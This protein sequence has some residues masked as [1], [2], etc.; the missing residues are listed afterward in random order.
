MN[1]VIGSF[2]HNFINLKNYGTRLPAVEGSPGGGVWLSVL[3][4]RLLTEPGSLTGLGSACGV[5]G[6]GGNL[7]RDRDLRFSDFYGGVKTK[8]A[9]RAAAAST[10]GGPYSL[11]AVHVCL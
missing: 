3:Y 10:P 2:L 7:I 6:G 1:P 5:W 11:Y 4:G 9:L 8:L